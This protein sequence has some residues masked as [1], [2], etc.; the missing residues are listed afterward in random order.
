MNRSVPP[1]PAAPSRTRG[2]S[3][4]TDGSP[5][6]V[7]RASADAGPS[8]APVRVGTTRTV[9]SLPAARAPMTWGE[10]VDTPSRAAS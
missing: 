7:P 10:A 2:A 9:Y 4:D 1:A 3:T 6:G 5:R 8:F